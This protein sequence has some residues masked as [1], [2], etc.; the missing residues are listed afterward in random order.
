[1]CAA[2]LLGRRRLDGVM[3][4]SHRIRVATERA[5]SRRRAPAVR[6]AYR[7]AGRASR[8]VSRRVLWHV[9]GPDAA[10]HVKIL[11][12]HDAS[13]LVAAA[14]LAARRC[15]SG[16]NSKFMAARVGWRPLVGPQ[17]AL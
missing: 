11:V 16:R 17:R 5:L 13:E 8:V 14:S 3:R 1:M 12:S 7:R 4:V 2:T 10:A 15:A 6:A 9:F